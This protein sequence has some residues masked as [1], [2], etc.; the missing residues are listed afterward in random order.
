MPVAEELK[1]R[2]TTIFT[3]GIRNG[4]YEE[5][6]KLSS[7]PGEIHSYLLD[8][9]EEFESLARRALHVGEFQY[10]AVFTIEF[11]YSFLFIRQYS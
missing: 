4:N 10:N 9:F 7:E 2:G 8:S 3:I 5:L 11:V 1:N 6:Y